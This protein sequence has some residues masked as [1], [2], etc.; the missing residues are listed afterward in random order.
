MKVKCPKCRLRFEMPTAKGITEVQCFCPRCGTPF[1]YSQA[2][3][4]DEAKTE[5]D[6]DTA[7]DKN[8]AKTKG[9][10]ANTVEKT[11]N[12]KEDAV[13]SESKK[14][15]DTTQ[16][17]EDILRKIFQER[18]FDV[19]DPLIMRKKG[20]PNRQVYFLIIGFILMI[21]VV[22]IAAK[23]L[24]IAVGHLT[25]K[26]EA[27][28]QSLAID[29]V[30]KANAREQAENN[31]KAKR[32]KKEGDNGRKNKSEPLPHWVPGEWHLQ[33]A[34]NDIVINIQGTG[35]AVSDKN[36]TNIGSVQ[37][38]G[39]KLVCKFFDGRVFY[40]GLDMKRHKIIVDHRQRMTK[41]R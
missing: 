21:F 5:E 27:T 34:D 1:T 31:R 15:K 7:T 18:M 13:V 29:S 20:S 37:R 6:D 39:N 17:G 35:I 32:R 9:E 4:D 11:A 30:L 38:Y 24:D 40:Y 2:E 12:T 33:T 23:G 10:A 28:S 25:A 3:E 8:E 14:A 26:D 22:G 41:D 19:R 16:N 36:H